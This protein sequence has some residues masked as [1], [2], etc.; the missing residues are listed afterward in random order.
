MNHRKGT[1]LV[2]EDNLLNLDMACDLLESYG[3]DTLRA[4]DAASGIQAARE[5]V[6]DLILMD[7]H[8]PQM[9][10]FLAT[11]TIK[12]DP[13]LSHI[14]VIAFT[15]LAMRG[16]REKALAAGCSGYISKP[17][18]IN[19]FAET[20][21]GY[22]LQFGAPPAHDGP[23]ST[24]PSPGAGSAPPEQRPALPPAFSPVPM[25]ASVTGGAGT[26][27]V[28]EAQS[29][30]GPAFELL[31]TPHRV[32]VVDDN[33][34]NVEL[35]KD[36]LESM[37]QSVL[38]AF[39]G[40]EAIRLAVADSP[41]LI[42]LDIMMPDMDGYQVLEELKRNPRTRDIPVI[43]V[44]ALDKTK[45]IVRGF[46]LGTYDYI[47]KPFKIEEV[48]ARVL[49]ALQL[50]DTQDAL[51]RERDKLDQI[52]QFSVDGI[53]L[54][55][56]QLRVVAANP[57]FGHWFGLTLTAQGMPIIDSAQANDPDS[58]NVYQLFGCQCPY[59][60]V[61][62]LHQPD[63]VSL[64][65]QQ[66]DEGPEA[67]NG[68]GSHAATASLNY[69]TVR[70]QSG[71]LR[72]LHLRAGKIPAVGKSPES[73]VLM[74]RDLTEEKLIE[75]RK[76]TFV[77]TLTHDLKTPIRAEVRALELL[78][79]GSF[80]PLTQD[81]LDVLNEII[82]SNQFMHQMVDSLLTTYKYED[83]KA[84]L[85]LESRDLNALLESILSGDL[86]TLATEKQQTL[87]LTLAPNLPPIWLDPME[88]RRVINNLVHNAISYTPTGGTITVSSEAITDEK[89][90][91]P[92]V[93]VAVRDTGRGI[94]PEYLQTL[95]DRYFTLAKKFRQVG[96]GLGL[97][98]S[99]QILQAHGGQIGVESQVGQ[100]SCFFFTLPVTAN[101]AEQPT[102]PQ[103]INLS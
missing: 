81:Q 40:Q 64:P 28:F 95:F 8:L 4:E 74:V 31:A 76:E 90:G 36:A 16:D 13:A 17:I 93:R 56:D 96:T 34:M 5:H 12:Q 15:A 11:Q 2:V 3:F 97:Y 50:K 73:Y 1:I 62:P 23:R 48:K 21:E 92:M 72:Y 18:D 77:A 25:S 59:G 63:Q 79:A 68:S 20:V 60:L 87:A 94:E 99:R 85:N 100:G 78:R 49:S 61:C 14:P 67:S 52:F 22:L 103:S 46:K 57:P 89:T 54:L 42:L 66:R 102:Q 70:T 38:S 80:G 65:I 39:N 24:P 82:H 69:I 9:D 75:Q 83:G 32:L 86:K 30:N 7:L 101:P 10:G 43:F 71:E 44:S 47:T 29:V 88:I 98:L 37:E 19:H 51:R 45:D 84:R 27:P 26:P 53:A 55:D 41:D 33:V 58:L 91:Q 6:P 35:L